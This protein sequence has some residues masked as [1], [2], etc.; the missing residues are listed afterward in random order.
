[1]FTDVVC[2]TSTWNCCGYLY[3]TWRPCT[4]V[5]WFIADNYSNACEDLF[6]FTIL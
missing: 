1:M 5:T 2:M 4:Y 6:E 3:R